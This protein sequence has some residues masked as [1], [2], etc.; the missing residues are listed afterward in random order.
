MKRTTIVCPT[1][2]QEIS[3]SNYQRHLDRHKNHPETFKPSKWAINHEGLSCQFCGKE[4]KNKNSLCNHERMC[5]QNPNHDV[6]YIDQY[7][8]DGHPVWNKGLTKETDNRV[9][10]QSLSQKAYREPW[11]IEIDDDGKLYKHYNN[12]KHSAKKNGIKCK[13]SFYEYCLLV[14]EAGL[15]SSDLGYA[16]HDYVLARYN[17]EGD[18]EYGKCR[19]ITRRENLLE[20]KTSQAQIDASK[21]NIKLAH[22]KYNNMTEEEKIEFCKT[23]KES[24]VN[25][26]KVQKLRAEQDKKRKEKE[27]KK[28]PRYSGE[29]N[30]HYGTMWITDG[31]NNKII[32]K[33]DIIPD[34][35]HKGRKV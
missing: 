13:L 6:C 21:R 3:R 35:W 34:G 18:Y 28:D 27:A 26:P 24:I 32:K 22:E 19:F 25:S 15:K 20:R 7:D 30:S 8:K 2:G 11:Q 16:G 12:K 5:K 29:H 23:I 31:I 33:T 4:C 14:K 17:D 1:C 10:K 9:M